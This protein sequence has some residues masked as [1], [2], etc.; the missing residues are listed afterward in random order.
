MLKIVIFHNDR[1][2]TVA[3]LKILTSFDLLTSVA[4]FCIDRFCHETM[5]YLCN[6]HKS[7]QNVSFNFSL[8]ARLKESCEKRPVLFSSRCRSIPIFSKIVYAS[9]G[10]LILSPILLRTF[11]STSSR[12]LKGYSVLDRARIFTWPVVNTLRSTLR[13]RSCSLSLHFANP[14]SQKVLKEHSK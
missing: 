13:M 8:Q 9:S 3:N 10:K 6:R 1:S 4:H 2:V 5:Q 12:I 14:I 7:L 11:Q